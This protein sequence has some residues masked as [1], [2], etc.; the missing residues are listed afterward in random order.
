MTFTFSCL[1]LSNVEVFMSVP[2][3]SIEEMCEYFQRFLSAAGYVF[4]EG[5]H[6]KP[7]KDEADYPGCADDILSFNVNGKPLIYD[8]DTQTQDPWDFGDYNNIP[9]DFGDNNIS[10]FGGVS[11]YSGVRGGMGEDII[12]L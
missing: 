1:D 3:L 7:V 6:I 10:F 9:C 8:S 2:E 5:E 12:K 11:P 4:D